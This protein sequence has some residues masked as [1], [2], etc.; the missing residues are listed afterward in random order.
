MLFLLKWLYT[1][2]GAPLGPGAVDA[3]VLSTS[4][5]MLERV[6]CVYLQPGGPTLPGTPEIPGRPLAPTACTAKS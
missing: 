5:V 4:E 3:W 2:T 6:A 1:L